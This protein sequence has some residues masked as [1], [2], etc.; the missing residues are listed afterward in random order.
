MRTLRDQMLALQGALSAGL[1]TKAQYREAMRDRQGLLLQ[2][3]GRLA[4]KRSRIGTEVN[5]ERVSPASQSGQR[6]HSRSVK[7]WNGKPAPEVQIRDM[8]IAYDAERVAMGCRSA[9]VRVVKGNERPVTAMQIALEHADGPVEVV[10][11][12]AMLKAAVSGLE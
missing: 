7:L 3:N 10:D 4:R 12:M 2:P 11:V 9:L 8:Q 1:I 6:G 5:C